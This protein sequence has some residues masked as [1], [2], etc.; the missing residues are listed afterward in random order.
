M[1]WRWRRRWWYPGLQSPT[2]CQPHVTRHGWCRV[3]SPWQLGWILPSI[4]LQWGSKLLE[5]KPFHH[6]RLQAV[7]AHWPVLQEVRGGPVI[8]GRWEVVL[9]LTKTTLVAIFIEHC[10]TVQNVC[11]YVCFKLA[12]LLSARPVQST[13]SSVSHIRL[14][15]QSTSSVTEISTTLP[16]GWC[17]TSRGY[18][19]HSPSACA[20]RNLD[21]YCI[22]RV[23]T[24]KH[25]KPA[26]CVLSIGYPCQ[27]GYATRYIPW[28][29]PVLL[30][31]QGRGFRGFTKAL[32]FPKGYN[33]SHISLGRDINIVFLPWV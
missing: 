13:A 12:A 27:E 28:G 10:R 29:R 6:P 26:K 17:N 18:I 31:N 22:I 8:S 9:W 7:P 30:W 25:L 15:R 33:G 2:Y 3:R 11:N 16:L 4:H 5:R 1:Y 14:A 32:A 23:C 21:R 20:W 19:M 24:L